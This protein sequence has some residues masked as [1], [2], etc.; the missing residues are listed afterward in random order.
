LLIHPLVLGRGTR[1]FADGGPSADL[2][3]IGSVTTGT[4]VVIAKYR[5]NGRGA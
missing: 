1:L 5:P 2:R 3:L 4:G